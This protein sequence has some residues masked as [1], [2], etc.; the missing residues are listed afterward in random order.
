M[1]RSPQSSDL[2]LCDFWISENFKSIAY[3]GVF[4]NRNDVKDHI[5]QLVQSITSVALYSTDKFKFRQV[6][7]L[8][9]H[10]MDC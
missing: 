2:T 10:H 1:A 6:P 8:C 9:F 7:Q 5:L 4:A 3:S